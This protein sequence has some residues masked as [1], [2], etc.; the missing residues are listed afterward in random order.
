MAAGPDLRARP[1]RVGDLALVVAAVCFGSTFVVVQGAVD[2]VEP[3]PFLAARFLLAGAVL[4]VL[5]RSRPRTR[6]LARDGT[7]AGATL[8]AGYVLQTVGLQYTAAATSAFITYLLVIF[9]PILAVV[10]LRRPP[11]PATLVGIAI[12]VVGLVLLTDPRADGSGFGRGELLTLACAVAFAAHVVVLGATAHRHDPVRLA[13]IQVAVVGAACAGPGLWMGGYRF[14]A[15]AVAAVAMT[16]IVATVL[17]FVL[18]VYGQRTVPPAR[19]ALVLLLEPVSAGLLSA[20]TGDPLR[21]VQ[22][23]GAAL[24]LVAVVLSE[25]VPAVLD[26]RVSAREAGRDNDRSPQQTGGSRVG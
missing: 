20:A 22:V 14:P 24:I 8:L 16:A 2:D 9:V 23:A 6:G 10:V 13:T 15:S 1:R 3:V 18:Q 4:W 19:A 12:A 17:A 25:V 5:G 7:A 26:R 21:A 11:H